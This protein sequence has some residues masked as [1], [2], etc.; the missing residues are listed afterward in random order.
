MPSGIDRSQL[1]AVLPI[2]SLPGVDRIS[3]DVSYEVP[4]KHHRQG[5]DGSAE[6]EDLHT[7]IVRDDLIHDEDDRIPI[8]TRYEAEDLQILESSASCHRYRTDAS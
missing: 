1:S 7:D 5:E 4:N 2:V 6:R 8:A 3:Y